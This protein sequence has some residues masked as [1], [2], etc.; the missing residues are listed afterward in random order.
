MERLIFNLTI[1]FVPSC[2]LLLLQKRADFSVQIYIV[3]KR[4]QDDKNKTKKF[5]DESSDSEDDGCVADAD[6]EEEDNDQS[7][8]ITKQKL[9][10]KEWL[11]SPL[12]KPQK[13]EEITSHSV[14]QV[15]YRP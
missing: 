14:F 6:A 2:T 3:P 15:N 5:S 7:S 12:R 1:L 11:W 4:G 8:V 13:I 9:V 10:K